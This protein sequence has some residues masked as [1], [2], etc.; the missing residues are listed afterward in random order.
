ML[1][2]ACF[3]LVLL[4]EI[5]EIPG[6]IPNPRILMGRKHHIHDQLRIP[7]PPSR[8]YPIFHGRKGCNPPC[9]SFSIPKSPQLLSKGWDRPEKVLLE[10]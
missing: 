8:I 4:E 3:P 1:P 9:P 6:F 5:W 10:F 2:Q 7:T